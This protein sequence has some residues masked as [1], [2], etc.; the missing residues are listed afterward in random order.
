MN[1]L[2]KLVGGSVFGLVCLAGTAHAEFV[3]TGMTQGFFQGSSNGNTVITNTPDDSFASFRTGIPIS[4][5]FQSGVIFEGQTFE[6]IMSGDTFS[7]G[8]VTYVNGR[9]LVGTSSNNA[10]LDFYIDLEDPALDPILLTTISFGIDATVNTQAG[11][12]PDV[13]TASFIQPA[14]VLIGG[15]LV[16][17]RINDLQG[18]VNVKESTYLQVADITVTYLSPVPEPSTYGLMG[19]VGL[20]SLG[21]YRRLRGKRGNSAVVPATA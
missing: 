7:F 2:L 9:T 6:N 17:F 15:R 14:P 8:L 5:S 10:L 1:K 4:G 16:T 18:V 11:T 20:M 12:N 21:A 19:A 3:L 13:F